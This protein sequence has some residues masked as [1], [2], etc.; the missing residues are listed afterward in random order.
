[1]IPHPRCVQ[2]GGRLP[3]HPRVGSR[4]VQI[5]SDLDALARHSA[6]TDAVLPA[7]D[8]DLV[9]AVEVGKAT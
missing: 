6:V 7:G 1:V 8:D 9:S 3:I 5:R 2:D 4:H